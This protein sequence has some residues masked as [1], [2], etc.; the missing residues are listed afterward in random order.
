MI[1]EEQRLK[2][3]LLRSIQAWR[4]QL[5]TLC[6]ELQLAPFQVRPRTGCGRAGG[7]AGCWGAEVPAGPPWR[8]GSSSFPS[9]LQE[10]GE[11][12]ILELEK[13]LRCQ[14]EALLKQ[15][16]ERKQALQALQEQELELCRVLS[17]PPTAICANTV[18]TLKELDCFRL[19]LAGLQ[20]EKVCGEEGAGGAGAA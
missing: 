10:E 8:P 6:R 20:A 19:H 15:K 16:R 4:T 11:P 13:V 5:A 3:R 7:R 18:P 12:T 1:A 17:V 2:E 9:P 14:V